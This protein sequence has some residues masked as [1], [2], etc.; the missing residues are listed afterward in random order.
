MNNN[1]LCK[2]YI[3]RILADSTFPDSLNA[4]KSEQDNTH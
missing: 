3:T 2:L 1:C 4:W